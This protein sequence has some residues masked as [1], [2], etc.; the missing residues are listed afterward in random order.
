MHDGIETETRGKPSVVL[1]GSD[2][3]QVADAKRRFLGMPDYQFVV[4]PSP[5]GEVSEA[6]QKAEQVL[7]KVVEQL[8]EVRRRP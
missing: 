7:P 5:L 1:V 6:R 3:V 4:V 8:I 2:F